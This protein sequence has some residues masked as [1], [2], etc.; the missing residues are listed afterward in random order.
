LTRKKNVTTDFKK[1]EGIKN[2]LLNTE[3]GIVS[4]SSMSFIS[5]SCGP[6]Q[7]QLP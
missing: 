1:I 7:S 6:S 4:F 3:D 5:K 2:N